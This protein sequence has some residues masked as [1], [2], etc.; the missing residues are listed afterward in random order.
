MCWTII[1]K[2]KQK[3]V[4]VKIEGK[5]IERRQTMTRNKRLVLLK[6]REK[7]EEQEGRNKRTFRRW[8]KEDV[9]TTKGRLEKAKEGDEE[10]EEQ[11]EEQKDKTGKVRTQTR[12]KW[13]KSKERWKYATV[14]KKECI[15][16]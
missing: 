13:M 6:E 9:W 8:N 4:E 2:N 15:L 1:R 3:I 10:Q 16:F 14:S 5:K 7:E 11:K 12:K